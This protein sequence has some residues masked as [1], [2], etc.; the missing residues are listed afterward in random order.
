ML[1]KFQRFFCHYHFKYCFSFILSLFTNETSIRN[2]MNHT[3][4]KYQGMLAF[5]KILS[6][7]CILEIYFEIV[8]RSINS[9]VSMLNLLFDPYLKY[10][11]QILFY[12]FENFYFLKSYLSFYGLCFL[13]LFQSLFFN[14]SDI[15]FCI[16]SLVILILDSRGPVLLIMI[17]I[18]PPSR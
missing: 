2:L 1:Y 16:L 17:S 18:G 3:Y 10:L 13:L 14:M 12:V 6:S 9:F 8:F 5:Q 11:F 15:L 7:C 4:L